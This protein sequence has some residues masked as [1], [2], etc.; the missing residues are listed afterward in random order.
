MKRVVAIILM[1]LY[2]T[3]S[4]GAT[5]QLH[6]CMGDLVSK[7][8][9]GGN[10]RICSKCGMK[11]KPGKSNCC[12]DLTVSFKSDTKHRP[13]QQATLTGSIIA[14]LSPKYLPQLKA[15]VF[16]ESFVPDIIHKP[17]PHL[18]IYLCVN[19]LLI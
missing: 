13:S 19:N 5:L 17:P 6:Y 7:T 4:V 3:T 11:K 9:F 12:N 10:S 15:V 8:I 2:F 14:I 16:K 18:P 1:L